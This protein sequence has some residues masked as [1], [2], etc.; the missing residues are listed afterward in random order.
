MSF[1]VQGGRG[2][3]SMLF[4]LFSRCTQGLYIDTAGKYGLWEKLVGNVGG[5]NV[6]R[7]KMWR[8]MEKVDGMC[9]KCC[10]AGR[11]K[12]EPMLIFHKEW[13]RGVRYHPVC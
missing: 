9:E 4:L 1:E 7:G 2:A 13:L 5:E 3:D 10:D 11:E 8:M 6:V 12:I